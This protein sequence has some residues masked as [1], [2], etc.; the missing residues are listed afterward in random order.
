MFEPVSVYHGRVAI[1]PVAHRGTAAKNAIQSRFTHSTDPIEVVGGSGAM[2]THDKVGAAFAHAIE[3]LKGSDANIKLFKI[4]KRQ[5]Y[6]WIF[7]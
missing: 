6:A 7:F 5:F 2:S 3:S 4:K 1:L